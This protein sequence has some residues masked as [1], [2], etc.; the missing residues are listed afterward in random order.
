M[1]MGWLGGTPFSMLGFYGY[2]H[3]TQAS[4][5]FKYFLLGLPWGIRKP[6]VIGSFPRTLVIPLSSIDSVGKMMDGDAIEI[7]YKDDGHRKNLQI[8]FT[9]PFWIHPCF[10]INPTLKSRDFRDEWIRSVVFAK[11]KLIIDE[12]HL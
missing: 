3:V 11:R 6:K 2:V 4:L 9:F 8:T 1:K 5:V 10:W 12:A 7:H